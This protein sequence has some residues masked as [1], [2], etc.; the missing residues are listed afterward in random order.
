MDLFEELRR[1][2][3]N[4]DGYEDDYEECECAICEMEEIEQMLF[5]RDRF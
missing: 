1:C 5:E 2:V 4:S 3:K